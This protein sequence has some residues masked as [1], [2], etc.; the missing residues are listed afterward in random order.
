MLA[1]TFGNNYCL[2]IIDIVI[3]N[4]YTQNMLRI[5]T[6]FFIFAFKIFTQFYVQKRSEVDFV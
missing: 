5:R 3:I 4:K 1:I 2:V 6:D